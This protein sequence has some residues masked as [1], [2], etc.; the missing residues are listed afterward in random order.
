MHEPVRIVVAT[1]NSD[2]LVEI[3]Q[4]LRA[5]FEDHVELVPRPPEIPDVEEIGETL[6]E[7]A[8]LKAEAICDAT[9]LISVA[10]DTG[11]FVNAL[12]GAPGV[13]SARY[14]GEGAT[15]ASNVTKLLDALGDIDDR[16]ASF[17]TV[18]IAKFPDGR[19]LVV[20]GELHGTIARVRV[21]EGGFGYDPIFVPD[22]TRGR[23]LAELH[24]SEKHG[25]S[26][27]GRAFRSLAIALVSE[28]D[29]R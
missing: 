13:F 21:G 22:E 25:I 20:T 8:L 15:Y 24:V 23:S 10:D 1:A 19:E 28:I 29:K 12:D 26:H 2:K 14:A 5:T 6:Y 17:R 3:E 9:G 4:I 27:R 7:N 11:L 18:A 16:R